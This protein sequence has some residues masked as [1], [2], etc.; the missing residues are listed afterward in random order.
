[1]KTKSIAM[2]FVRRAILV[3]PVLLLIPL[4]LWAISRPG[5]QYS[6]EF[7]PD[8]VHFPA[9]YE[10]S[11]P[12]LYQ[13]HLRMFKFPK[14]LE[15]ME[16][17]RDAKLEEIRVDSSLDP[18]ST[19]Q[20]M[21]D[22][23]GKFNEELGG[24]NAERDELRQA[25]LFLAKERL[26]RDTDPYILLFM[27]QQYYG[28]RSQAPAVLK[29][30][31]APV[32]EEAEIK[33]LAAEKAG[34]EGEAGKAAAE[35]EKADEE[36][37]AGKAEEK[38]EKAASE[39]DQSEQAEPAPEET[40]TASAGTPSYTIGRKYSTN[41]GII[42]TACEE[43]RERFPDFPHTDR[44]LRLLAISKM[45]LGMRED[46]VYLWREFLKSHRYSTHYG[47][48]LFRMAEYEFETPTSF[49]HFTT[50]AELYKKVLMHFPSGRKRY[51]ALYKK[52]WAEYLSHDM[53]EYAMGS[54]IRLYREI[55]KSPQKTEE[56][57]SIRI[58]V[59]EA[60][61]QIKAQEQKLEGGAIFGR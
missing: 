55:Q 30:E 10:K 21:D 20:K 49:D 26:A 37:E 24:L 1:M 61:K 25:F 4:S 15:K 39:P 46:T 35:T 19:R 13:A 28:I 33:P 38:G 56:M 60:I 23:Y 7:R 32:K 8:M 40:A 14:F 9:R 12:A 16:Q 3:I 17:E 44:A 22:V 36:G 57:L 29:P 53:T 52:A 54:F 5:L 43:I 6:V 41:Y 11:D 50:A 31:T 47:D 58:E 48:V 18:F 27:A 42:I 2:S 45:E 51:L 59:L 34:E